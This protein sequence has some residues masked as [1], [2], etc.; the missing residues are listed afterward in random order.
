MGEVSSPHSHNLADTFAIRY[1]DPPTEED[2]QIYEQLRAQCKSPEDF[3]RLSKYRL[4]ASHYH[5]LQ[6]R[7]ESGTWMHTQF[8]QAADGTNWPTEDNRRVVHQLDYPKREALKRKQE[9]EDDDGDYKR[10]QKQR[11]DNPSHQDSSEV[12]ASLET[13]GIRSYDGC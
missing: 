6:R 13:A 5:D 8:K 12:D 3:Q 9:D 10:S 4:P 11:L 7:L 1:V 2:E